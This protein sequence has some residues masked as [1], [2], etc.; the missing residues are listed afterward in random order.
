[1]YCIF[2]FFFSLVN[3]CVWE[4]DKL[5][6]SVNASGV[7]GGGVGVSDLGAGDTDRADDPKRK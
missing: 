4:P 6:E 2:Y 1:M 3:V 5:F 7:S